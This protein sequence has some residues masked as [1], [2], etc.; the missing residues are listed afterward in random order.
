MDEI[1]FLCCEA[2]MEVGPTSDLPITQKHKA[3][4]SEYRKS[5][6]TFMNDL[7][8]LTASKV[9][10][11]NKIFLAI[12]FA[13]IF[14]Y[15]FP[16][17]NIF[18]CDVKSIERQKLVER[19]LARMAIFNFLTKVYR[20]PV[21]LLPPYTAELLD[22]FKSRH[23]YLNAIFKREKYD[24]LKV[25][26]E[27]IFDEFKDV[28]KLPSDPKKIIALFE[29]INEFSPDLAYI[30][31][32]YFSYQMDGLCDLMEKKLRP[33]NPDIPDLIGILKKAQKMP[34]K[35][36]NDLMDSIRPNRYLPNKRDAKSIKYLEQ[37][38]N[39]LSDNDILFLISSAN[40]IIKL[41]ENLT[42]DNINQPGKKIKSKTYERM[43]DN[44]KYQL[45]RDTKPFYIAILEIC[46]L[47][48]KK[49][50]TMDSLDFNDID[51]NE[52]LSEVKKSL[53][54]I[55]NFL[56]TIDE[57]FVECGLLRIEV[58][59]DILKQFDLF[60]ESIEKMQREY[61]IVLLEKYSFWDDK[62][63]Y[64]NA[65]FKDEE[66]L[67][68]GF[69]NLRAAIASRAQWDSFFDD[70]MNFVLNKRFNMEFI[71]TQFFRNFRDGKS[72][73]EFIVGTLKFAEGTSI[74]ENLD[75]VKK[76]INDKELLYPIH[77]ILIELDDNN[78]ILMEKEYSTSQLYR[79]VKENGNCC[80]SIIDLDILYYDL[81][82][83]LEI[84]EKSKMASIDI[85]D[86]HSID[87]MKD[88]I[89]P[90]YSKIQYIKKTDLKSFYDRIL[91]IGAD[92]ETSY[93]EFNFAQ[94]PPW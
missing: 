42:L 49:K 80:L 50:P 56:F 58:R 3:W 30:M 84:M 43:I 60:M 77:P 37:I 74:E 67:S 27:Q 9:N 47:V 76:M 19:Q 8:F 91:S 20:L 2:D 68:K 32:P 53:Y 55:D 52:L 39:K 6:N 92:K 10:G 79:L 15:C 22:F 23:I 33:N 83:F 31:S 82:H 13:D 17:I 14:E 45:I 34:Y 71:V 25:Y 16:N 51:I 90:I 7:S 29:K 57:Q 73:D 21:I 11:E 88:I 61:L 78:Y 54:I 65:Y 18:K 28:N 64:L 69:D 75:M 70:I 5:L 62:S 66:D 87:T 85:N 48:M 1:G 93:T 12:D 81:K 94:F 38:N 86:I 44:R 72:S 89:M 26:L 35:D 24:E 36:I 40:N 41:N 46:K 4:A 63:S 59:N